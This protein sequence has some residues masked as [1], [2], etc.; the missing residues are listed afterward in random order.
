MHGKTR[1]GNTYYAC[2]YRISYGDKAA[3]AVGHGKWQ[4]MR[5]DAVLKVIDAF[6]ATRIFGPERLSHFRSQSAAL[7]RELKTDNGADRERL[8]SQLSDIDQ[9]IHRQLAAIENG[10][11]PLLVGKRI[12]ALKGEHQQTQAAL[13]D[14]EIAARQNGA[15]DYE[16]ARLVLDGIP[17]LGESLVT[18][19]PKLR[20][21]VFD[22]FRL[23][24]E[25][26]RNTSHLRVKALVSSAF[27]GARDLKSLVTNGGVAG[28]GFEPATFG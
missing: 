12:E 18:A 14:L 9:R 26:D 5:E 24:V 11:D 22:A 21:S 19:E 7:A 23:S 8:S 25:I 15:V 13:T 16:D 6:F 17:D 4:Y 1:K 20:R 3:E 28:A 10:V 27:T 2:C